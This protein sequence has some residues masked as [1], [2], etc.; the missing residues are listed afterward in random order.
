MRTTFLVGR[1]GQKGSEMVVLE[2]RSSSPIPG[3]WTLKALV[4]PKVSRPALTP[5]GSLDIH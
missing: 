5:P 1:V 4:R 2:G 3:P